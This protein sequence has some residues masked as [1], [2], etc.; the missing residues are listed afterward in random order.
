MSTIRSARLSPVF[1]ATLFATI[2]C[3]AVTCSGTRSQAPSSPA[4]TASRTESWL[5]ASSPKVISLQE[6]GV[7]T[8][9]RPVDLAI[10]PE[11]VTVLLRPA[12]LVTFSRDNSQVV[13]MIVGQA[14]DSWR[15][16]DFDPTDG[17]L[18]VASE[19]NVSL[20]RIA[21]TG[22]RTVVA[23]PRVEGRGG[24]RQIRIATDGIYATPSGAA[25][26]V[27]RLSRE[28]K[29]LTRSFPREKGEQPDVEK[30]VYIAGNAQG[31]FWL[32]RQLDWSVAGFD[33]LTGQ[34][35]RAKADGSWELLPDRFPARSPGRARSLHGEAVGTSSESW[36]FTDVMQGLFFLPEG[37][38]VLGSPAV[39]L[40][41]K[42]AT[43]FR[44]RD[45]KIERAIEY[46]AE[47]GL[48]MAVSDSS[49]FAAVPVSSAL[50]EKSGA[51]R[52]LPARVIVGRFHTGV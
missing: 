19:D 46:C 9:S 20:L 34:L 1:S 27:W 18:W 25:D 7:P 15:A 6:L 51:R 13:D 23:G 3:A 16:I 2:I 8:D 50:I 5:C 31:G 36:Y 35:Y 52:I 44:I 40:Q 26:A 47:N 14:E 12:R 38:V 33:S 43:L 4:A 22:E 45:G 49:G 11:K 48:L 32:A 21:K 17:S 30:D 41:S 24:L 39:G 10:S 42:G 37:P 28:G 29:L